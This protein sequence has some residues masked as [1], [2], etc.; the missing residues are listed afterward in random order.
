MRSC[1]MTS[2]GSHPRWK[3]WESNCVLA[4]GMRDDSCKNLAL[5]NNV[6]CRS[7]CGRGLD[8]HELAWSL[9]EYFGGGGVSYCARH[10]T[11]DEGKQLAKWNNMWKR[12]KILGRAKVTQPSEPAGRHADLLLSSIMYPNYY[13]SQWSWSFYVD[14]TNSIIVLPMGSKTDSASAR[15]LSLYLIN[16]KVGKPLCCLVW[17]PWYLIVHSMLPDNVPQCRFLRIRGT[18][19]D[20]VR[21]QDVE[22]NMWT[23]VTRSNR[24]LERV[25]WWGT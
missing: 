1:D 22:K 11:R 16:K 15:M 23:K 9:N 14:W 8:M 3:I 24:W 18:L 25:T 12:R 17:C 6:Y 5:L 13:L 19:A 2:P 4:L 21:E 10:E 20:G 7:L